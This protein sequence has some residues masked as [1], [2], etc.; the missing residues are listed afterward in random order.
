MKT[1]KPM[2]IKRV[3]LLTVFIVLPTIWLI[4]SLLA[5]WSLYD[6]IEESNDTQMSQLAR[7]LLTIPQNQNPEHRF[8]PE[9]K[10]LLEDKDE[11]GE[12]ED[13][14]MSFAIWD[15]DGKLLLAD[16]GS[17]FLR[18]V[19]KQNGF[20]DIVLPLRNK[21]KRPHRIPRFEGD[22]KLE[23]DKFPHKD[24][25]QPENKPK[26]F[27][28]RKKSGKWR[29]LYLTS[30]D[31]QVSVAVGQNVKVR[32]KMVWQAIVAQIIPW[33][34]ALLFL[35]GLLMFAV[36]QS[37]KPIHSLAKH[38]YGRTI[39]DNTP[40]DNNL[41]EEISPLVNSLN[42]LFLRMHNA[43]R[44]EQNFTADAAHELRSP[45]AA[46]KIQTEV[47]AMSEDEETKTR[48]MI[49]IQNGIDRASRMIDQLL[50]LTKL[51]NST[52]FEDQL[53]ISW[54]DISEKIM[55]DVN[56][57][58]REKHIRLKRNIIPEN[59]A[60]IL[61]LNGN[62]VLIELMLRNLIDNAIRYTPE[63]GEVV[64][65]MDKKSIRVL[66]SGKGI[67]DD[68]IPRITERFFRPAGQKELGSGLGLSIVE[69]IVKIHNLK[70]SFTNRSTGGLEV[71][72]SK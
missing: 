5:S 35:L 51:D 57:L 49:N 4:A 70:I 18:F 42:Q 10:Q 15:Q 11:D 47:L 67:P 31:K 33:V 6:E 58:A 56:R 24:F 8:V 30:P 7:S 50:A 9:L 14:Y 3:L 62:A 37:L 23:F 72:I 32:Y 20:H 53:P 40:I 29:V 16:R 25:R 13:K 61:P 64:L 39:D 60:E 48:A 27:R 45:L 38:L 2:S 19:P 66:D 21:N 17:Y 28:A 69:R 52:S 34:I 1:K 54:L 12:A 41:P 26:K 22:K 43:I 44:R 55:N 36:N 71:K 63:N 59:N 46:L 68:L 65:E